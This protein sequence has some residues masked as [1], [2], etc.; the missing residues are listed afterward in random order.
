[1]GHIPTLLLSGIFIIMNNSKKVI[2]SLVI[3]T[4]LVFGVGFLYLP[5]SISANGGK[6][7]ECEDAQVKSVENGSENEISY[8]AASGNIVEGVCIKSGA[9]MFG[10]K[11]SESLGNGTYENGCYEVSGVGTTS[12][13]VKRLKDSK[14]C[15][16]ISHIDIYVGGVESE[17]PVGGNE[18]DNPQEQPDESENDSENSSSDNNNQLSG[19]SESTGGEVLSSETTVL[20]ATGYRLPVVEVVMTFLVSFTSLSRAFVKK[21]LV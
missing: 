13:S 1:M 4:L 7:G 12:V 2:L 14:D 9:N 8:S 19:S 20:A 21:Y 15:Q 11:H 18:E 10:D 6:N 5:N 3:T 17:E 16:G